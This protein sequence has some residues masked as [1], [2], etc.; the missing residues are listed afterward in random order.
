[1]ARPSSIWR[2]LETAHLVESRASI[3]R[4]DVTRRIQVAILTT[5]ALLTIIK[6]TAAAVELA[7]GVTEVVAVALD[8]GR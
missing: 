6:G 4:D 8:I 5:S 7:A 1:M 3:A 2:C